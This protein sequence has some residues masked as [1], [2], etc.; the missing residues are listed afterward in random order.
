[1]THATAEER[2]TRVVSDQQIV[3]RDTKKHAKHAYSLL[4]N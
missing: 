3:I 1:M 4:D 2:V